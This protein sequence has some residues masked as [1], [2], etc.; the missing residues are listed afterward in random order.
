MKSRAIVKEAPMYCPVCFNDS[1]FIKSQGVVH[2]E[3][4]KFKMTTGKF[5][6]N[7][8]GQDIATLD[9]E[10]SKKIEEYVRWNAGM[11]NPKDIASVNLYSM[12]FFCKANSCMIGPNHKLSVIGLIYTPEGVH[13][14]LSKICKKHN[15]SISS[16]LDLG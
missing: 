9:E 13:K 4:N 5:L 7:L 14:I 12:D 8:T 2:V 15:A 11:M 3:I 1:L 10:L 6:F 16:D